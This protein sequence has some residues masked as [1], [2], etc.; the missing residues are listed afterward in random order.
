MPHDEHEAEI[1][2]RVAARSIEPAE[3]FLERVVLRHRHN[4]AETLESLIEDDCLRRDQPLSEVI[5]YLRRPTAGM[6]GGEG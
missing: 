2:T 1:I 6:M 4:A 5:E 3:S